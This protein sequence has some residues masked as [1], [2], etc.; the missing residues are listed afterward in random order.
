MVARRSPTLLSP[1]A[2]AVAAVAAVGRRGRP[3]VISDEQIL[4]T[5]RD[6]FLEHGIRA[7]TA[8]VALRAKVSEGTIFHR[9]KSKD[10]LFRAAMRFDP[11]QGPAVVAALVPPAGV[12]DL[13][14]ALVR[15]G[16]ELLEL[17]RVVL[18]VMMMSWSNPSGE[19]SLE[20]LMTKKHPKPPLAPLAVMLEAEM[21]SGRLQRANVH[22]LVRAFV[23]AIRDY[24]MSALLDITDPDRP[25]PR[26]FVEGLVDLLFRCTSCPAP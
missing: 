3:P 15:L 8:E 20:K 25:A 2:V 18:P 26:P 19:Y 9:F 14:G 17:G 5:A 4:D 22:I 13:R 6:V 21:A 24:T 1:P 23:G 12:P 10:A 16:L 11:T 7:T